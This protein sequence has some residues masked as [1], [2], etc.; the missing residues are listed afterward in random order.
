MRSLFG[1]VLLMMTA[2]TQ[3]S[4]NPAADPLAFKG[5]KSIDVT[6]T[7]GL[8]L[9]WDQPAVGTVTAYEV[10]QQ[11][12]EP[13]TL[14]SS[15]RL[16]ADSAESDDSGI[17]K[18]MLNI[19]DA[20]A[21]VSLGTL[22]KV[23]PGDRSFFELTYMKPGAYGFQVRAIDSNG[24]SDLNERVFLLKL[25]RSIGYPGISKAEIVEGRIRLEW[26]ALETSLR[27]AVQYTVFQGEAFN[28][29]VAI[30][31][32]TTMELDYRGERPGTTLAFGVRSTDPKGRTDNN[33]EL[34]S[35]VV[36]EAN[37]RFEGCLSAEARG[38]DRVLVRFKWPEEEFEIFQ[39]YR[40]GTQIYAT[41]DQGVT[42]YLDTGLQEGETYEY[43]CLV[44]F[45]ELTL[46]GNKVLK[47]QTL[48]SN[49]PG[50]E[51]IRNV[52]I[53]S[54]KRARVRWGVYSGVPAAQYQIFANP[55]TQ[56]NWENTPF[57]VVD[58]TKLEVELDGLG[59]EL[60]YAFGVRACSQKQVCDLN[61][62]TLTARTPDSGAP[63]TPGVSKL[64]VIAGVLRITAPWQ[65][66]MGG[67]TRRQVYIKEDGTASTNLDDYRLVS[68][69]VVSNPAQ[70]PTVINYTQI[71]D[72]SQYHV[73]VRDLDAKNQIQSTWTPMSLTT[74][75]TTAPVFTGLTRLA[76]G[77]AG[78]EQ[79]TL[80]AVF[81]A[82]APQT[83]TEKNGVSAYQVYRL[84]GSGN[85]CSTGAFHQSIPAAS[86][87]TGQ[88]VN[89][90]IG[91]LTPLTRYSLCIKA[92]DAAGNLSATQVSLSRSTLDTVAPQFDG[93][94]T[95]SFDRSRSQLV[96]SWN[97]ATATDLHEYHIK[98]WKTD[99]NPN[100]VPTITL[101]LS[102]QDA[103]QGT[104]ISSSQVS[105][106][107]L[108]LIYVLVN[109]CDNAGTIEGGQQN[110]SNLMAADAKSIQLDDVEAPSGFIGIRSEPDLGTP[111]QGQV[112][113]RWVAPANWND[114]RGF[115]IY[116][117]DT[118]NQTLGEAVKD[119]PCTAMNCPD[120]LTECLVTGLD[121]FR[122][123]SFHVRAYDSAGNITQL[124]PLSSNTRKRT[125][126]TQAPSFNSG[127]VATYNAGSSN[128]SWSAASDNQYAQEPN[129][130]ITYEVYRKVDTTFAL[131]F[132]TNPSS[133]T[134]ASLMASGLERTWVDDGDSYVSGKTYYYTICVRDGSGNRTCDGN[135]K[136]VTV[137][138][139]TPP[140][141]TS[142]TSDKTLDGYNWQL[143]WVATDNK[144]SNSELKIRIYSK[145]S[146]DPRV[147][148]TVTDF[149][150]LELNSAGVFVT[151]S[152]L[153]GRPNENV[154]INY[155]LLVEDKDNNVTSKDLTIYST[156][157]ISLTSVRADEGPLLGGNTVVIVG[158]GF[159]PN[160]KVK[161]GTSE[162]LNL[163][164][165]S[166]RHLMC[167]APA[168]T[169]GNH[170]VIAENPDG[171]SATVAQGYRY[172]DPNQAGSCQNI[173][174]RPDQ[175]GTQFAA[176]AGTSASDPFVICTA[177][178]LGLIR[179]QPHGRFYTIGQNIDL[180]GLSFSPLTNSGQSDFRG[181]LTGNN[182]AILNLSFDNVNMDF[183]GL[184]R[185]I[186]YATISNLGLINF[187][188]QGRSFV[189]ALAGS[190]STDTGGGGF[191]MDNTA[192]NGI[193]ATGTVTGSSDV[194]GV[195]GR[196]AHNAYDITSFVTV[197]GRQ[198]AGGVFGSKW[199]GGSQLSSFGSV[200]ATGNSTNCYVGGIA[201]YWEA[202]NFAVQQV[203]S[204]GTV[205]CTD[206]ANQNANY[207]GGLF[208]WLQSATLT[209][210]TSTAAVQGKHYVGGLGGL[211][212]WTTA[213]NIS[214]SGAI[215][216][217]HV[218]GG[219]AG[220][221]HG[222]TLK[223][224]ESQA[225]LSNSTTY[226]GGISGRSY[227]NK[228]VSRIESCT[229]KGVINS[230]GGYAGGILGYGDSFEMRNAKVTG[231]IEGSMM[232]GGLVGE[233][234]RGTI[235]TSESSAQLVAPSGDYIGGLVGAGWSDSP[236][237][238]IK[239]SSATGQVIGRN[240]IGGLVGR[241]RGVIQNS[242]TLGNVTG[243]D[244]VGGLIGTLADG[245]S[246]RVNLIQ[247]SHAKG[248][249]T[250]ATR[251][252]GLVG[253]VYGF[254]QI[255]ESHATGAV[256]SAT[257][258]GGLIGQLHN[259][260]S[261][262]EL[263][264]AS[265]T[266][267]GNNG[268]GGFLGVCFQNN[269]HQVIIRN[270]YATGRVIGNS[271]VGGF[272]GQSGDIIS[273]V[274]AT[275]RVDRDTSETAIGGLIGAFWNA[276]GPR[277]IPDGF[278][279]QTTSGRTSSAGGQ[280]KSTP[281]MFG[282]TLYI[283]FDQTAWSFQSNRYPIFQWQS[284]AP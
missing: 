246:S 158:D 142:F 101:K 257:Y 88:E 141:I 145:Y 111:Q 98:I 137:P 212:L 38:A 18:V 130:A 13:S 273:Q 66:S 152:R 45:G 139:L 6:Q 266:V 254:S 19:P 73:V 150:E 233:M 189:G 146:S 200:T 219:I 172:C 184:F 23:V 256:E 164:R 168:G 232:L 20:Q 116:L 208:G 54:A 247:R 106:G 10:Y 125:S 114:Y 229:F 37:N 187:N 92:I 22:V 87:S 83:N 120:Q 277:N 55:G 260:S 105:L 255:R 249:V 103:A 197:T 188:L 230:V 72:N 169:L 46:A 177:D 26:P 245:D 94:Q 191:A 242:F 52:E 95:L 128:L 57:A 196:A 193:F 28:K 271:N 198:S 35:I 204:S 99:P 259:T 236:G 47:V 12:I 21:P 222:T 167:R 140:T 163:T 29:R 56:V 165:Y 82:V 217:R 118:Q 68:T 185:T 62:V 175:W 234:R 33:T 61:D 192:V 231:I 115:K 179:Q 14:A 50:F 237:S 148:A 60:Q 107:S 59:D 74:G 159:K 104:Q 44:T 268:V 183:V 161:I 225:T 16:N 2:C 67:I 109:A 181:T 176:G 207:T 151:P 240:A 78:K 41:K 265:G 267:K 123:Y 80:T 153:V 221:I 138:D 239:D 34:K 49:P 147:K 228:N 96:L 1:L 121:A 210:A 112:M 218:A 235:E 238:T 170:S 281:D 174:Y 143:S 166:N 136:S 53:L 201:G 79:T 8:V 194:G 76:V 226:L 160:I 262:I 223:S 195:I 43:S 117:V 3:L 25:E 251:G 156:N 278:W 75:D 110:C 280:G 220:E 100:N 216:S 42:D 171:S 214:S 190:G 48:N 224:C 264:Y 65:P 270:N 24:L 84:Q 11:D 64:E 276:D 31:T 199:R 32:A 122:T 272:A 7:G 58:S 178:Q 119:C 93:L 157:A 108:E 205:R 244:S 133:D 283:N 253:I 5:I 279:D 149:N 36:P 211:F 4:T 126:D 77:T 269:S 132:V 134:G 209:N 213:E 17:S 275:G 186:N 102:K 173:C 63:L 243:N 155:L 206:D 89:A 30:S 282:S 162:C 90:E 40:N 91:G 39:I 69:L 248:A 51:G 227:N 263:N 182:F 15:L 154:Y 81:T 135:I 180:T 127:L 71:S 252:G 97:P 250:A 113:V 274:Y 70:P 131:G 85:A 202:G 9:T 27:G 86:Y 215:N 258:A 241:Y 124:D 284:S 129:A 261:T 144:T 203:S